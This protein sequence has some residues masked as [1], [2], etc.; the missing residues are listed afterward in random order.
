[1]ARFLTENAYGDVVLALAVANIAALIATLGLDDGLMQQF[2]RF[3]DDQKKARGVVRAG[4]V[5]TVISS[6]VVAALV[7]L[8]APLISSRFFDDQSL[9]TLIRIA[10][11]G[12]P[13]IVLRNNAVA[14]A[15][16]ARSAKTHA[17][18][19]QIV[20]PGFR[21]L[22]IAALVLG[23]FK[24][25]GAVVGQIGSA[26]VAGLIAVY[27]ALQL[28]PSIR[29]AY[30]PMYKSL[31]TFS[32]PLIAMQGMGF[33]NSNMD[34]YMLGYF[35]KSSE[36]G[37]YNIALQLGNLITSVLVTVG[38]LLPPVITR[39]YEEKKY[40]EMLS[41]YQGLTKWMVMFAI[42]IFIV[43]FFAPKI[44]IG[45]LFGSKYAEG[46][47]ALQILIAGKLFAIFAGLNTRALIALGNNRIVSY[48]VAV[49]AVLNFILNYLFIP[50]YG[51]E[52]GAAALVASLIIGNILGSGY[53]YKQYGLHPIRPSLI[54]FMEVL[55]FIAGV[56]Y[57]GISALNVP[58][59]ASVFILG[60]IYPFIVIRYALEPMDEELLVVCEDQMGVD[61][62]LI[63]NRMRKFQE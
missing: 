15:R 12:V 51:I 45:V 21:L 2:P 55:C 8:S 54:N 53:L 43:M 42:P 22:F 48:I 16:G 10:S 26:T 13:F 19:D 59:W 6:I 20:Q 25:A 63:K 31:L 3:E 50:I 38:F 30:T 46:A 18:V 56:T 47:L 37:V 36:V 4:L 44:V 41:T 28:L 7:F 61:L 17:I 14:L 40:G 58:L 60:G 49:Q 62:G 35:L 11:L 32:L 24:A 33:L 29:G 57:V 27:L 9:T 52:G 39:L 34:I 5:I 23:G 1:M